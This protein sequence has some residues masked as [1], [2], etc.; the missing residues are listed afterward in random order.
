MGSAWRAANTY[1]VSFGFLI[2]FPNYSNTFKWENSSYV[3][4]I[5]NVKVL[6]TLRIYSSKWHVY[7]GECSK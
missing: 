2:I 6:M 7:A 3:G 1:P 4:G 5:E